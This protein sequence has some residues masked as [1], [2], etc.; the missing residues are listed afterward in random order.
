[1]MFCHAAWHGLMSHCLQKKKENWLDTSDSRIMQRNIPVRGATYIVGTVAKALGHDLS[2]MTLSR[3]SMR[4]AH[5]RNHEIQATVEQEFIRSKPLLH[6]DGKLLP[7]ITGSKET[8]DRIAVLATGG[9][10]EM[11]L[12]VAQI[13][14][15][16]GKHQAEACLVQ[17][18]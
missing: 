1:M 18:G 17:I 4:H 7:D 3:S 10:E 14:R 2:T 5:Y 12:C 15:G 11:L 8:V 9:G 13:G 16:T 6:W